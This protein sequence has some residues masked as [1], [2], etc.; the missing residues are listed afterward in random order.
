[1]L[2]DVVV[3]VLVFGGWPCESVPGVPDSIREGISD[4][5]L[6]GHINLL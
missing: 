1:M 6:K 2:P 3:V 5:S 4:P